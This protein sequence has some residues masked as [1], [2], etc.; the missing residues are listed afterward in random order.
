MNLDDLHPNKHNPRTIQAAAMARLKTSIQRDPQF[1]TLR[2]IVHD[3]DG[4]ILGGNMRWRACKELGMT[5]I[6]DAWAVCAADLTEEQRRRF[7]LVDNAPEGM[8]GEWDWEL[9]ADQWEVAE[10]EGLGFDLA[11]LTQTDS[12]GLTDPDAVPEPPEEPITK[13][14]DLWIL[15]RHRLLCGDSTKAEEVARLMDGKKADLCLTDPP[16]GVIDEDWDTFRQKDFASFTAQ[17][18]VWAKENVDRLFC[19]S[20][21]TRNEIQQ[22][23]EF[24]YTNVRRVVWDKGSSSTGDG[25]FWFVYE[26]IYLCDNMRRQEFSRPKYLD[27]ASELKLH[28]ESK[29]LSRGAVDVLV[30]GKKTGLCFR[31]EEGACL[32]TDEQIAILSESLELSESALAK[33]AKARAAVDE[34][35]SEMRKFASDNGAR[36][37]DV[38]RWSVKKVS[39]H[40]CEKPVGLMRSL[41]GSTDA[42]TI[43]DPF[44]GSGTTGVAAKLEGRKATL[45]EMEERYCEIAA[46]RLSQGV[47]F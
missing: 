23:C 3:Q 12:T 46:N 4:M 36:Y 21:S 39:D 37:P 25:A 35:K 43:L 18:I 45:I 29:G 31:W 6:P 10:L 30:R 13:P 38:L 40:P 34:T 17:W 20:G 14:G 5:E 8:A 2:P 19:F 11:E 41:V 42:Q 44:A 7:I 26:D 27:F 22:L 24:F 28:R 33:L 32:P 16:Y 1:M 9:L 47:L 15:G